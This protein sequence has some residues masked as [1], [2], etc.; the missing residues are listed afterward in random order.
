VPDSKAILFT[1]DVKIS[2]QF[3]VDGCRRRLGGASKVDLYKAKAPKRSSNFFCR[4]CK[5]WISVSHD[6]DHCNAVGSWI[7][8]NIFKW[9]AS[10]KEEWRSFIGN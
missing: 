2:D 5:Y 3:A 6:H 1:D 7:F 10:S 4:P 9:K 8:A